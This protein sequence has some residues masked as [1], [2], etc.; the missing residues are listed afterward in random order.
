MPAAISQRPNA[1]TPGCKPGISW[2]T[3]TAGPRSPRNTVRISPS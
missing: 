3:I 2:I 1:T